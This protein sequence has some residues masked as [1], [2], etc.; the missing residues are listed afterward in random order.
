MAR[1][2]FQH[3]VAFDVSNFPSTLQRFEIARAIRSHFNDEFT[4]AAIQFVPNSA[5]NVSFEDDNAKKSIESSDCVT[6]DGVVCRVLVH[7]PRPVNVLVDHYPFE[8]SNNDLRSFMESY[9]VVKSVKLQHYLDMN[10]VA[11]GSRVV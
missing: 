2:P 7:G 5:V 9:G 4:V 6:I 10:D 1:V 3:T 11:T 8:A